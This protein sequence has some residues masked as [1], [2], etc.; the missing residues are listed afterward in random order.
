MGQKLSDKQLML[1]LIK[2][3]VRRECWGK[4]HISEDDLIKG[5]EKGYKKRILKIAGELVKKGLLVRIP[6]TGEK[7]YYLNRY[8]KDEIYEV[9]KEF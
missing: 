4:Y 8:Q 6:Y 5:Q 2:K 7:H 1:W 3:L 9:V